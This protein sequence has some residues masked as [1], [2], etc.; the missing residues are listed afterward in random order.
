MRS[1]LV[2]LLCAVAFYATG[3]ALSSPSYHSNL[4]G[5][6]VPSLAD[7]ESPYYAAAL[8][9]PRQDGCTTD[10]LTTN[11]SSRGGAA[12]RILVAHYTVSRNSTGWGDVDAIRNYFNRSSTGAS[13][14]YLIDWEGNCKYI[15]NETM[16]PWTQTVF[17]PYSISIEFIAMGSESTSWWLDGK[18]LKVGAKVFA[19]AAQRWDIP[20][21]WVDPNGCGVPVKG[22][23]DHN[24]LECN[25]H[26]DV[27]PNFPMPRFVQMVKD[28]AAPPPQV[29]FYLMDGEGKTLAMSAPVVAGG[30]AEDL[31]YQSF[32]KNRV[33]LHI[34]A[35]RADDDVRIIRRLVK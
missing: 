5:G 2:V 32:V 6:D 13:S 28:A 8:A 19:D 33:A 34:A 21:R 20:I 35:L 7:G 18:G 3:A 11:F 31:R 9:S 27:R 23:T 10:F 26:T 17:N 22:I 4:S 1:L 25:S 15:V 29:L 24:A 30:A 14:T 12:P 16:K